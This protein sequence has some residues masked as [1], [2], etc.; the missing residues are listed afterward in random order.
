MSF[1]KSLGPSSVE[2][3]ALTRMMVTSSHVTVMGTIS[4]GADRTPFNLDPESLSGSIVCQLDFSLGRPVSD[5][6]FSVSLLSCW[7]SPELI[8]V[9]THG[10]PP[11]V[12]AGN[13]QIPLNDEP[14][15]PYG[16]PGLRMISI[17]GKIDDMSS[18]IARPPPTSPVPGMDS[19][20][21][22]RP[23]SGFR[24]VASTSVP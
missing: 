11:F 18:S 19:H 3:L 16:N 6:C 23:V 4:V 13:T 8:A 12:T 7:T 5:Q 15:T 20:P 9:P 10:E 22:R 14:P 1:L 17:W 2:R 21:V 24:S